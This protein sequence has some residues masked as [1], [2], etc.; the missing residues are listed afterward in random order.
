LTQNRNL[1]DI[2]SRWLTG[3][4]AEAIIVQFS[5]LFVLELCFLY[6]IRRSRG[7]EVFIF[8]HGRLWFATA[9]MAGSSVGVFQLAMM[10]HPSSWRF[11]FLY[12]PIVLLA[13]FLLASLQQAVVML[14]DKLGSNPI[15]KDL[16]RP[17]LHGADFN[18][19]VIRRFAPFVFLW[20][21]LVPGL[22]LRAPAADWLQYVLLG[23]WSLPVIVLLA[24]MM[25]SYQVVV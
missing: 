12:Y 6:S 16:A 19:A 17:R 21:L 7:A 8:S 14:V 3:S 20:F 9:L 5:I 10:W 11:L 25:E 22:I 23:S 24:Q 15:T 1:L 4:E 2:L 18:S 13:L